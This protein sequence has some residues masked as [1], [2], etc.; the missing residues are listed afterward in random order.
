M[1]VLDGAVAGA[2]Y[3]VFN[4]SLTTSTLEV[5]ETGTFTAEV[6]AQGCIA[7][8]TVEVEFRPVP[9]FDLSADTLLCPGDV[10]AIET[11]LEDVLVTWSTGEV[12][13]SIEVNQPANYVATSQ[14]SGCQH[15]DS[16]A[17]AISSSIAIPLAV[18]YELCLTILSN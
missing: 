8:D 13:T 17:V 6:A 14:I 12:G 9:V 11:G 4:D 15:I 2:D 3:V 18:D 5:T 10:L 7:R 16:M 1:T